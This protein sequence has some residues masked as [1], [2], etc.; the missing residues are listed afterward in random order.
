MQHPLKAAHR[1]LQEVRVLEQPRF[2][3]IIQG[4]GETRTAE[5]ARFWS[6]YPKKELSWRNTTDSWD[7]V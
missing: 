7:E 6:S 2:T 3:T 5:F 1:T 4:F